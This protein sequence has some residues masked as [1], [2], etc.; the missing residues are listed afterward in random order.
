M[1]WCLLHPLAWSV[2]T[3]TFTLNPCSS[4]TK[5]PVPQT[6]H[7]FLL[8]P[9][10]AKCCCFCLEHSPL[11]TPV[12]YLALRSNSDT[13]SSRKP[14]RVLPTRSGLG[15]TQVV[16]QLIS[17][18]STWVYQ[19][20]WQWPANRSA[21]PTGMK[22][23][24]AVTVPVWVTVLSPASSTVWGTEMMVHKYLSN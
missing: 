19:S 5:I 22:F 10:F 3:P 16:F 24:Q 18:V 4:L 20:V 9:G 21:S 8:P 6:G 15:T 7:A 12:N 11:Q 1:M 17:E 13:S 2:T 23:H 14:S